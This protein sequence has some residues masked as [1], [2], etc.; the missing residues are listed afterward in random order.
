MTTDVRVDTPG[1]VIPI[2]ADELDDFTTEATEFLS[3]NRDMLDFTKF[4]LRQ[5]VY[6]Q[7]QAD[8]QMIRVKLPFGGVTSDQLDAFGEVA[9]RFTPLRKG[10]LTTR[11]NVQYHHVPLDRAF[12]NHQVPLSPGSAF[13]LF[14][15]GLVDQVG[16]DK[17]RAFGKKRIIALLEG[18]LGRPP[19]EQRDAITA[20]F[21]AY[22]GDEIRRDDVTFLGFRMGS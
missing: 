18:H 1:L 8:R 14:S 21:T 10:H 19:A 3:G 4:R 6:G 15:D 2:L 12:T 7:R 9:E 17:R 5:G 11:E 22:Q 20:A 13:Y 16:G